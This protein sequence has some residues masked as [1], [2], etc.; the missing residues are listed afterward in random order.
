LSCVTQGGHATVPALA[1]FISFYQTF[2]GKFSQCKLD[3]KFILKVEAKM[4]SIFT[5][6]AAR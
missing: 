5:F 6:F 1:P 3:L 2:Y 4:L